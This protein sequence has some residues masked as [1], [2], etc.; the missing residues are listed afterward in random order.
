MTAFFIGLLAIG[1]ITLI[2]KADGLK[3]KNRSLQRQLDRFTR[4]QKERYDA[5]MDGRKIVA[6]GTVDTVEYIGTAEHPS[7]LY[8]FTDGRTHV[9]PGWSDNTTPRYHEVVWAV[10]IVEPAREPE[11]KKKLVEIGRGVLE[12]FEYRD[13]GKNSMTAFYFQDGSG[14]CIP[15]GIDVPHARGSRVVVRMWLYDGYIERQSGRI[16]AEETLD[17]QKPAAAEPTVHA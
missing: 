17:A 16:D 6:K 14:C 15:G 7:T 1:I 13:R 5:E 10:P 12:R 3:D 4:E 8:R 11:P 2:I 9:V